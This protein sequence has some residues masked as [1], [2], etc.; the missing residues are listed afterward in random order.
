LNPSNS[1]SFANFALDIGKILIL[2]MK[3]NIT[4]LGAA[5]IGMMLLAG[6]SLSADAQVN[7]T[8][9]SYTQN[10]NSLSS[11]LP[12]GWRVDTGST[13]SALGNDVSA[14]WLVTTPN[15]TIATTNAASTSWRST[16]GRFKNYASG[17]TY[18]TYA[19]GTETLQEADANRALGVRQTGSLDKGV[20]FVLQLAN[21][22]GLSNFDMSFNLQ[23]LD[24]SSPRTTTWVVDYGF[25]AAPTVFTPATVTGTMVTGNKVYS[26]NDITVDFGTAL[27]NQT[28]PVF[29]RIVALTASTGSGNRAT[30][31]ID[32]INLTWTGGATATNILATNYTPTGNNVPL[33]TSQLTVKY[34][35]PIAK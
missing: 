17:I 25:G 16:P 26:R 3:T 15:N 34:D 27:N 13:A 28:G 9:T 11:G 22:S 33:A 2:I 14:A 7:L 1:D 24:T 19:A 20:A 4:Q 12:Q 29:I 32:N 31:A 23:S 6:L 8:G 18:P 5:A 21:T 10:F 35:N 30:T